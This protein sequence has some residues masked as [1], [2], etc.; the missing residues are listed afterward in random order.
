MASKF[1][2]LMLLLILFAINYLASSLHAR[3]DLTKEKR[4]TLSKATIDLLRNLDD[5]VQVDVFLKGEFPSGFRKLAN[6]TAEFL[7]L[8]KE[9]NSSRF[10]YRFISP[11]D[12]MPNGKLWGD[13]LVNMGAMNINLTVRKNA[14]Q[15]SNIIFP[16]ALL[17]YKGKQ[18]LV[19]LFPGASRE[20]SQE[21]LNTAEAL[22]EYQF[23]NILDKLTRTK[24]S[25]V[26]YAV[27]NGEP[28]DG[29]TY[30]LRTALEDDYDFR[31]L[32]LKTQA[33]IPDSV[34]V[35]LIVKPSE[36]FTEDQKL[37]IDQFVM[38]GGKLLCFID[39]LYAEMDS[40]AL[41]PE[42]I[43][44]D[45]NLKL[46]D[47]FFR[48]GARINTD[49]VMDLRCD[50]N[51]L[52]VGGTIEQPQNE[53]LPWNYFPFVTSPKTKASIKLPGYAG[54]QFANSI[55][56]IHVANVTKTP[57][58]VTSPDS[59]VISTPALISLNENKIVPE[60]EKFKRDAIPVAMLLEGEFTSLYNN[61]LSKSQL[62][63]L[64]AIGIGFKSSSEHNKMIIVADGDMVLNEFVPEIDQNGEI[65][66]NVQPR[67]IE[68][69]WNK[70]TYF[71]YLLQKET[72]K[73]FVP[74]ANREFLLNCIEYLENKP[75]I[76]EIRN[77][78]IVLR[79]LDSPKIKK[80][81]TTWQFINIA[82]PILA[83]FLLGF[84]Y[85]LIRKQKYAA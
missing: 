17:S 3:F 30:K 75:A 16:V 31:A 24:K 76:S 61:R 47:L 71:E 1:W 20:I 33:R 48:Y 42:T 45:R 56:T 9:R 26:A 60:D 79:L 7:G 50:E 38:H 66:Q 19:N 63:T 57:L 52:T 21:E 58:L 77:K 49:L 35:L 4:Y 68:M 28:V 72:G 44:Y 65:N 27:G 51:Y 36:Q 70:Y 74:V 55:D 59:R 32:D 82:L 40:F 13:S 6:S 5:N 69:G 64:A 12:E 15:S 80:Q 25:G 83:I 8:M 53:F 2:W 23:V 41:K 46:T 39:N 67:P 43:A 84:I 73:Y 78:E 22:M 18:S 29:R 10:H 85:Q 81:K 34:S 54:I 11:L 37:K 62:D 14:G